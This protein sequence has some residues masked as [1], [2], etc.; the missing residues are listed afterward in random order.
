MI[1]DDLF[2]GAG[3]WDLAAMRLGI[4]ARG[5]EIMP[6]ARLTR[7]AAGLTTIHDDVWTFADVL[8]A[9][10]R[11]DDPGVFMAALLI[12]SPPCQ[13]FSLAGKGSG[14]KALDDVLTLIPQ[15]EHLT[16]AELREAGEAFGDDRTALVLTPLWYA[17]HYPY[18]R[19]AWE[20][21]PTVLPVWEACAAVLRARDWKVWTG[22]LQAEQYGVAQTRK[23]SF[24]LGSLDGEVSMPE[25]THSRYYPRTPSKLDPDVKKWV[26]MAEALGWDGGAAVY[27]STT[28]PNSAKRE[29]VTPAPTVAFGHDAASAQWVSA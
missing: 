7:E 15:V 2:A 27:R 6:E 4:E 20:Q 14:R 9:M 22:N 19:V 26:S 3:G 5:V 16:L 24:L 1:A 17:L 21:V 13:T 25:P 8:D 29:I 18:R 28:M 10:L 11:S 12:A 23:R